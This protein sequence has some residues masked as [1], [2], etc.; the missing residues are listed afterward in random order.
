VGWVVVILARNQKLE[1]MT[2]QQLQRKEATVDTTARVTQ[3]S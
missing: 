2:K 1:T 3:A